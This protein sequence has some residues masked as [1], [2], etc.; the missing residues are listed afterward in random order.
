[1]S[2]QTLTDSRQD[3][4]ATNVLGGGTAFVYLNNRPARNIYQVGAGIKVL[5]DHD[6]VIVMSYDYTFQPGEH[7]HAALLSIKHDW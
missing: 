1:M 3:F 5:G 7:M 2:Y 4:T 6:V